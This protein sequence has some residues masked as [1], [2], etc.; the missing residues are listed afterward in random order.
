MGTRIK[1]NKLAYK[2]DRQAIASEYEFF[3]IVT[4]EKCI[5]DSAY[6]LDAPTSNRNIKSI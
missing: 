4:D 2:L 3:T 5:K 6:I 1:T